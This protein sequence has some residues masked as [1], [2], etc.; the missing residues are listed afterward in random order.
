MIL[1]IQYDFSIW[2]CTAK[3]EE[4][5]QFL[6]GEIDSLLQEGSLW[7]SQR[8]VDLKQPGVNL[9]SVFD[10]QLIADLNSS[11]LRVTG[12][13][14]YPALT[15]SQRDTGERF[16]LQYEEPGCRPLVFNWDKSEVGAGEAVTQL[17]AP[18]H[19]PEAD[20]DVSSEVTRIANA[21]LV[22]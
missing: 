21:L 3:H 7:S 11:S 20:V 16:G 19:K 12:Q 22:W 15:T 6:S 4:R 17:Q 8:L 5:L 10:P 9:P 14:M 18:E 1:I 2:F 13:Q